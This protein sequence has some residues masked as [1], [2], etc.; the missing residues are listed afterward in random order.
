MEFLPL[1]RHVQKQEFDPESFQLSL[2]ISSYY[3]LQYSLFHPLNLDKNF[4]YLSTNHNWV[5]DSDR[6]PAEQPHCERDA[7]NKI[8]GIKS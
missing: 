5:M 6:F 8:S 7:N 1:E 2:L 3:V 4:F